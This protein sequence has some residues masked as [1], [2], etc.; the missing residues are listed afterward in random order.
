M[1]SSHDQLAKCIFDK[2]LFPEGVLEDKTQAQQVHLHVVDIDII[3]GTL[4]ANW[5]S[6][7][8]C[9]Q[10][11]YFQHIDISYIFKSLR[12]RKGTERTAYAPPSAEHIQ[13][14]KILSSPA[15][16]ASIWMGDYYFLF[17]TH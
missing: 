9:L 15:S 17:T 2:A 4:K 7:P 6:V 3:F 1:L 10:Q 14:P 5:I 11:T 8:R 12:R 13:C 16:V